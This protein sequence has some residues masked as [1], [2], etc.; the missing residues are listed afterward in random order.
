LKLYLMRHGDALSSDVDP[1]RGLSEQGKAAV[2]QIA[3]SLETRKIN[4]KQILHSNK[5][6]A[7]QTAEI[8]NRILANE[9]VCTES[10]VIK[11][12][13]DPHVLLKQIENEQKDTLI[14]SHLPFIPG[15]VQLLCPTAQP[16]NFEPAAVA[17]LEKNGT[18]WALLWVEHPN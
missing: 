12:N 13:D 8:V 3:C 15:L 9:M 7:R 14:V 4:I 11:P 16:I 5:A 17:C 2:S 6:R 18:N 10:D 1:Q